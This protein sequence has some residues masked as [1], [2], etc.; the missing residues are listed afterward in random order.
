MLFLILNRIYCLLCSLWW[1]TV[2]FSSVLHVC[3]L[4]PAEQWAIESFVDYNTVFSITD[5]HFTL[6]E[7]Q[8][9][10][11][12]VCDSLKMAPAGG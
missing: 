12:I 4:P 2:E 8:N 1:I 9:L 3:S 7:E 11:D 10:S 6:R 5:N